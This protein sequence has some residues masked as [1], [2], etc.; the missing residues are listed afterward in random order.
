MFTTIMLPQ[1]KGSHL[2][3]AISLSFDLNNIK[4]IQALLAWHKIF[5][6]KRR[7][8]PREF[9]TKIKTINHKVSNKLLGSKR[10]VN[11]NLIVTFV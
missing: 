1:L 2:V 11:N 8:L 7:Q 10:I 5:P 4:I 6:C 3:K 9:T